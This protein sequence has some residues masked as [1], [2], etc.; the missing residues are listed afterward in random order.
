M[1]IRE[2]DL[3]LT[4]VSR[5]G[6]PPCHLKLEETLGT[7][8]DVACLLFAFL[9]TLPPPFPLRISQGTI[10]GI[11]LPIAFFLATEPNS[12]PHLTFCSLPQE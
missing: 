5:S 1:R 8:R 3:V 11:D 10:R 2:H 9:S 4:C 12:S 6:T 7:F